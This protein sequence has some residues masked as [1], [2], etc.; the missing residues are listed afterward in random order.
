[1]LVSI[2]LPTFNTAAFINEAI[3]SVLRQTFRNYE[4]LIVDDGSTDS[5]A[6]LVSGYTE[7]HI[8]YLY[9]TNRGL[10]PAR[11]YGLAQSTAA[12]VMFLDS[13]DMLI[14]TAVCDVRRLFECNG[15]DTELV[16]FASYTFDENGSTAYGST[17]YYRW[18][19]PGV[20]ASGRE[21]LIAQLRHGECPMVAWMYAFRRDVVERGASLRFRSV[22]HEDELFTPALFL[23]AGRTVVTNKLLVRHRLRT[24][25]I[26]LSPASR[27]NVVGSAAAAAQWLQLA[28]QERGPTRQLFLRCAADQYARAIRY[29]ARAKLDLTTTRN[30]ITE[31][32]PQMRTWVPFDLAFA[33][34][35][36]R[37]T[38]ELIRCRARFIRPK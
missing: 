7:S 1:M 31:E 8:H 28:K 14:S 2:I 16:T 19:A 37:I 18:P 29:A 15:T 17:G 20:Y 9:Q 21:A 24:N 35:S 33:S 36:R 38:F 22:I 12:H 3:D 34:V 5:T 27:G 6:D 4:L 23:R 13:D 26:M 10:G 25:S 32:Y 30:I 11:N